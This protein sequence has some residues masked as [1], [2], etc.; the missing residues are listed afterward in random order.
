MRAPRW[1]ERGPPGRPRVAPTPWLG[2]VVGTTRG[3]PDALPQNRPERVQELPEDRPQVPEPPRI[4]LEGEI[5]VL[6]AGV[7]IFVIPPVLGAEEVVPEAE[8]EAE[9]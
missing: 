7:R 3:R 6:D 4:L 5:V 2:A 9:V 8:G 1:R